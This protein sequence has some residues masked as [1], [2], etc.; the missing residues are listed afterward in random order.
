MLA[1]KTAIVALSFFVICE[2]NCWSQ[3]VQC[4]CTFHC[5]K[6]EYRKTV[7]SS[8]CEAYHV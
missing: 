4:D 1:Q 7:N 6:P 8:Y 5:C 3:F 2:R